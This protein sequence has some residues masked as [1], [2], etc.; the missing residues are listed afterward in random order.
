MTELVY[1]YGTWCAPCTLMKPI[2]DQ[3]EQENAGKL[4]ITRVDIDANQQQAMT[5]GIRNVPT[6]FIFK[7]GV[8]VDQ[9]IGAAPKSILLAKLK[10]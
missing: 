1:Y 6:I 10:I 9:Q 4:M 8:K 3:L 2:L 7:N 5:A